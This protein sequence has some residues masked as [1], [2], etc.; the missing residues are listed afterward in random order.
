MTTPE[1]GSFFKSTGLEAL[2][3]EF[4]ERARATGSLLTH[5]NGALTIQTSE[6]S[7]QRKPL[8]LIKEERFGIVDHQV[9]LRRIRGCRVVKGH[10]LED[11]LIS[12][13]WLTSQEGPLHYIYTEPHKNGDKFSYITLGMATPDFPQIINSYTY[14]GSGGECT[15]K[16]FAPIRKFVPTGP[17][18]LNEKGMIIES[19]KPRKKDDIFLPRVLKNF[20]Y[21]MEQF[22]D[23]RNLLINDPNMPWRDWFSQIDIRLIPSLDDNERLGHFH[24][25]NVSHLAGGAVL[26][27]PDVLNSPPYL[28]GKPSQQ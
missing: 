10:C 5:S 17:R 18:F 4:D 15:G 26:R 20:A 9:V 13:W 6:N 7:I 16:R 23:S 1:S 3:L 27:D 28:P 22:D 21:W 2:Y 24:H 8:M 25:Y 12:E 14:S 19:G 11:S